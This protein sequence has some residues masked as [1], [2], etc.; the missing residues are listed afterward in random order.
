MLLSY[1]HVGS[2]EPAKITTYMLTRA[3]L[4]ITLCYEI[5]CTRAPLLT[6]LPPESDMTPISVRHAADIVSACIL[7]CKIK[8]RLRS[9]RSYL[10]QRLKASDIETKLLEVQ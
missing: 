10:C 7:V 5:P 3:E 1:E 6:L 4:L 2:K 8:V 9:Y